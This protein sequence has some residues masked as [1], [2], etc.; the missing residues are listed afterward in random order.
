MNPARP[1]GTALALEGDHTFER[2]CFGTFHGDIPDTHFRFNIRVVE[3]SSSFRVHSHEYSELA[4]VLGG[5]GLHLTD[6]ENYPLSAG[7]VFVINGHNRHGFRAPEGLKLYNIMFD[8]DSLF[9]DHRDLQRTQGF[10]ALFSLQPRSHRATRF[11]QRLKLSGSDLAFVTSLLGSLRTEFEGRAEERESMVRSVFL[12]LVC[13][14]SRIY[15]DPKRFEGTPLVRLANAVTHI[16]KHFR[17]VIRVKDLAK[18]THWSTSQFERNFKRVYL[19]SPKR[20][21]HDLRMS[22]S[23]EMLKDPNLNITDVALASGFSSSAFFSARFKREIG[24][25]PSQYRRRHLSRWQ[26]PAI[27]PV[28]SEQNCSGSPPA[29]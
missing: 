21:I 6:H 28:Q 27:S 24:E 26:A 14:L 20:F 7:D 13:V 8:P 5:R 15:S 12:L 4:V 16:Q 9:A 2:P 1:I 18:I 19:T 10:R 29:A 17:E 3:H 25:S 23:C 11:L 22:E